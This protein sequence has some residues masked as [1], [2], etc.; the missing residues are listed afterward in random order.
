MLIVKQ[1]EEAIKTNRARHEVYGDSVAVH[2]R[3]LMTLF[4]NG[5]KLDTQRDAERSV[6]LFMITAKLARY[7]QSIP[8]ADSAHDLGI[9]ALML[10]AL[11]D[12]PSA[13]QGEANL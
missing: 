13:G 10:E 7:C 1:L 3:L 11:D 5:I 12:D 6:M 2:A 9:Y 8:H 4:P